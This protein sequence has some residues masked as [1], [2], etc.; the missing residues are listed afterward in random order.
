MFSRVTVTKTSDWGC[1][2]IRPSN[3]GHVCGR[4]R[5]DWIPSR[6]GPGEI[7]PKRLA[8]HAFGLDSAEPE[9]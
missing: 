8:F 9:R 2:R 7:Q 5:G 3:I 4:G 6:H 1:V